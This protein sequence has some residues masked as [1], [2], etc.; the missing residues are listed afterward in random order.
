VSS[1]DS[2]ICL[3]IIL[4]PSSNFTEQLKNHDT[5]GEN[6]KRLGGPPSMG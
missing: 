5:T 4:T 2:G 1:D 3:Y 6:N